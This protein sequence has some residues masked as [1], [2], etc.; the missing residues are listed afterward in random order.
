[1]NK[2]NNLEI[3]EFYQSKYEYY[4]SLI[5]WIIIISSLA[6]VSYFISDCQLFD[7]F[8]YETLLPRCAILL[9]MT[10]FII[11]NKKCNKYKTMIP[12]AYFV[13]HCAMWCT[14]WSIYYLPIKMHASEGFIIMHLMFL[15]IGLCAPP[16]YSLFYHSMVMVNI[17]LSYPFN[18][19]ENLDMMISLGLP[20]LIG[21][22]L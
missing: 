12:L 9:P 5:L 21:I 3:D 17:I 1:M 18:R 6:E 15:A 7:R 20:C 13:V 2:K 19:Y 22:E 4:K 16:K 10:L 8:A 14:I 11:I